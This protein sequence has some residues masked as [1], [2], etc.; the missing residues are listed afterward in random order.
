M[1]LEEIL[2]NTL[3]EIEKIQSIPAPTFQEM[4]RSDYMF[5]E[6]RKRGLESV[7]KDSIGN[8]LGFLT[9]GPEKPIVISAHLDTV[10]DQYTK[11]GLSKI[12]SRWEG[13]GVGDNTTSLAV[14]LSLIDY[15]L[16]EKDHLKGGIWFVANVGEEGLGNLIGMKMVVDH[17]Q[18]QVY[19]YVVLEGIGLGIIYHRALGVKR[20]QLSV[21][22]H[23]GHAWGEYGKKSAISELVIRIN[24]LLKMEIPK[25]PKSSLN[26]GTISGGGSINSIAKRAY[27]QFEFRSSDE[28]VL[29]RMEVRIKNLLLEE[30]CQ[31]V[32]IELDLIGDRPFGFI[33][34]DHPLVKC[35]VSSLNKIGIEP[36][37][38]IGSTDASYPLSKGYPSICVCITSGG[39]VHTENEYIDIDNIPKGFLQVK[40]IIEHI[41]D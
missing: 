11:Y 21:M 26:I 37:L 27:C 25:F 3:S 8:V 12:L 5:A 16:N 6:F 35:A 2:A 20:Y 24:R 29:N 32:S 13:A 14:L 36:V 22:T 1:S 10:H 4:N 31:D 7:E 39:D 18:D 9:G 41:W 38:A 17:F 34:E 15:F 28:N 23:G 33:S 40:N 30:K 19:A